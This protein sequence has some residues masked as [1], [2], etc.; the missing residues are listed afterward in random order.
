MIRGIGI[1]ASNRMKSTAKEDS[2]SL[3]R[4]VKKKKNLSSIKTR[5]KETDTSMNARHLSY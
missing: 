1:H 3:Y 4:F 5:L 2:N